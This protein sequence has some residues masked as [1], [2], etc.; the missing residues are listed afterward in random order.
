MK[1]V[2]AP[3]PATTQTETRWNSANM[4]ARVRKAREKQRERFAKIG[5]P[6]YFNSEMNAADI[7]KTIVMDDRARFAIETSARRFNLSGR[8]FHRI[9][10]VARTIA[11]LDDIEIITQRQILEALQFRK[12]N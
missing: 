4:A 8:A 6:I 1:T 2:A 5:R 9:M 3:E 7:E 11:D 10:K 12:K